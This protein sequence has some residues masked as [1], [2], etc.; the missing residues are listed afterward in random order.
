MAIGYLTLDKNS[1]GALSTW[2][3]YESGYG[4]IRYT[5]PSTDTELVTVSI[6]AEMSGAT[7]NSAT[8]TYTLSSDSGTRKVQFAGGGGDVT[9]A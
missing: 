9:N 4:E 5:T 2:S 3:G 8:L 6:P 1:A 7:F